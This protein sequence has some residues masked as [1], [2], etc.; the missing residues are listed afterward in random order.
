LNSH[1]VAKHPT[2]YLLSPLE[3]S[4]AAISYEGRAVNVCAG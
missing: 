3:R 4:V 2:T 1:G